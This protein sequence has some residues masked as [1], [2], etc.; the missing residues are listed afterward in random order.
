MDVEMRR[1]SEQTQQLLN[2]RLKAISLEELGSLALRCRAK[3]QKKHAARISGR[4]C[5]SRR[6]RSRGPR[7]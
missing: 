6:S 2:D 1:I 3:M 4:R 5:F 7:S